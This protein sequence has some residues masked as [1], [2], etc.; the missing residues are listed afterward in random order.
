[1]SKYLPGKWE[2]IMT[3]YLETHHSHF[4]IQCFFSDINQRNVDGHVN[5]IELYQTLVRP[6]IYFL[7]FL[8]LTF[9]LAVL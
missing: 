5:L 9:L 8:N 7:F 1:M 6:F 2:A 4:K 3:E